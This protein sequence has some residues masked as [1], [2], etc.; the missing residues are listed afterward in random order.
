MEKNDGRDKRLQVLA[1]MEAWGGFHWFVTIHFW[2]A[3]PWTM[4][5]GDA[6]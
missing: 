4:L 6:T 5:S 3:G 2:F 1:R